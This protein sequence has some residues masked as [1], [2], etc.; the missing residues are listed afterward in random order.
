MGNKAQMEILGLAIVVVLISLA[1]LFAVQ[2]FLL[3]PVSDE[4][5]PAK[6]SVVAANFLSSCLG[7]TTFCHGRTVK[8]L[9]QD[10]ALSGA[11]S[12]PG[13]INSCL[14][15]KQEIEKMLDASLDVWKKECFFSV[16]G[17]A[18]DFSIGSECLG[19]KEYKQYPVVVRPGFD[20]IVSL[21]ICG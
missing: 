17:M 7:T 14:Y 8:E 5:K 6:E 21:E 4:V 10:C 1:L 9:L 2:F 11:L 16:N 15:V 18:S 20:I 12:C 13:D 19:E 3:K